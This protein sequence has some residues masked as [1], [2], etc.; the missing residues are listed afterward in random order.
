MKVIN[1]LKLFIIKLSVVIFFLFINIISIFINVR[2]GRIYTSRI[3]HLS[4]NL[5]NY[6]SNKKLYNNQITFFGVDKIIANDYLFNLFK[7]KKNLY[8]H[9][10]FFYCYDFIYKN[11]PNSR[12]LINYE[13]IHPN[14][15]LFSNSKIN[16]SFTNNDL[17]KGT[18]LLKKLNIKK[19]LI[20]IHNR[21]TQYDKNIFND[22]NFHNYRN[23]NFIKNKKSIEYLLKKKLSVVRIGKKAEK[24]NS[25]KN[26]NYHS[27]VNENHKPFLDIFII[28]QSMFVISC[29][30]GICDV[31]RLF[32]KPTLI[33]NMF[34]F[35]IKDLCG[36]ANGSIYLPK[37]V[38][39]KKNGKY[40]KISEC[41]KLKYNIHYQG[42]FL[43]DNNLELIDNTE[44]EIL[45]ATREMYQ[46]IN[47]DYYLDNGNKKIL[48]EFMKSM[49]NISYYNKITKQ[50]NIG[51]SLSF[52]KKNYH[53]I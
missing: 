12:L 26:S 2:I 30:S 16:I 53:L 50:L 39:D 32:R 9:R 21:S 33:I 28:K 31:A 13:D 52:L 48:V 44:D 17:I 5:D 3:G 35:T 42:K 45:E 20:C 19:P 18:R 38:F 10:Y 14:Y 34:P 25:I 40:L 15:N 41:F 49:K 51:I 1:N 27:L 7:K 6:L 24:F 29:T 11:F 43:E 22:L 46:K 36:R 4:L 8:F 23:Y 47:N 37:K